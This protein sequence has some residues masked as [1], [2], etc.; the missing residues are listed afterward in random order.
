MAKAFFYPCLFGKGRG[1]LADLLG[2][3]DPFAVPAVQVVERMLAA[4]YTSRIDRMQREPFQQFGTTA[5]VQIDDQLFLVAVSRD[6]ESV[7][8]QEVRAEA[9]PSE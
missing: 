9:Y 6:G 5:E 7:S 4:G 1:I 3:E 2:A 8:V